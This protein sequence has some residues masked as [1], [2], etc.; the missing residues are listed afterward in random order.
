[1][2]KFERMKWLVGEINKHNKNYYV[3]DNPT[4]SDAEYDAL[5]YEL[6]D[7]EK[8][9]GLTNGYRLV[10]NQGEDA[11]Q[12]VFHLHFH[13]LGGSEMGEKIV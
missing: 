7:L 11:G 1:M 6:V 4:I 12:T 2:D 10:I 5:Y 3:Y 8:E 9:L 13:I